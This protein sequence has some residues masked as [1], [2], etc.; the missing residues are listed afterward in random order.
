[1]GDLQVH[2]LDPEGLLS[3]IQRRDPVSGG[4]PEQPFTETLK[5]AIQKVNQIQQ[6]A[7]RAISDLMLG[8]QQDLHQT[9]ISLEKADISFQLMMQVRNKIV[10]AYEEIMRMQI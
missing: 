6:E 10:S 8:G 7:D 2:G 5:D 3:K 9:M 4:T 1:M